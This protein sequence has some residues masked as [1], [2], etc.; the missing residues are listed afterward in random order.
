MSKLLKIFIIFMIT[1][2]L[3][4]CTVNAETTNLYNDVSEEETSDTTEN[5]ENSIK[6]ETVY[7]TSIDEEMDLSDDSENTE[8][9]TT[10]SSSSSSINS[11][12]RVSSLSSIPEANLGLNNVLCIILI[13]IGVLIILLAIAILIRLK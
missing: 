11:S 10:S 4:F 7:S 5:I 1:I 12:A 13:A 9:T 2:T 3:F 8:N 6:N